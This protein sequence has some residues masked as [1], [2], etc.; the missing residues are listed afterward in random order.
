MK[1]GWALFAAVIVFGSSTVLGAERQA[2]LPL[3]VNGDVSLT[4]TDFEAYVQKVPENIRDD[5]RANSQRVRPT[6]DGLWVLRM[7]G[8]KGRAA[9]LAR[10]ETFT[11]PDQV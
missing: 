9:G 8:A 11:P 4:T 2:E 5:F 3:V 1:A 6:V 10:T 7:V